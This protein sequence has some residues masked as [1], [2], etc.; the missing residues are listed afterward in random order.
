[1][2][3]IFT[4][5]F[6]KSK[7]KQIPSNWT[8]I[9]RPYMVQK[10]EVEGVCKFVNMSET[11]RGREKQEEGGRKGGGEREIKTKTTNTLINAKWYVQIAKRESNS[12]T[13]NLKREGEAEGER[14]RTYCAVSVLLRVTLLPGIRKREKNQERHT[15]VLPLACMYCLPSSSVSG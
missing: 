4:R 7:H 14:E 9:Q 1:M 8:N 11:E 5:T 3:M 6:S 13:L 2:I 15:Q 10:K 12:V